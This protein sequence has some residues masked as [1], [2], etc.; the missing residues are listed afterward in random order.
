MW[1]QKGDRRKVHWVKWETLC[2]PKLEGGMGFKDLANFNDTLLA[3]QAW[4]LLHQKNSLFYRVFKLRF[5]PNCSILEAS[6]LSSGS[7]AWH[8]I[9][10][11]RDLLLKGAQWRVG[12]GD[13]ISVWN[14]AWLPSKS[15][16]RIESQVVPGF[17]E[18]KV[19]A[20]IGPITKKWDSY[21]LN[22]L[23]TPQEAKLILSIPLCQNVVEDTVV[24]PF[25]P[26]GNYT[27]KLSTRFLTADQTTTQREEPEQASNEVWKSIWILNVQSKVR[28]FL[29][30]TYH[31]ALPVKQ[32]LRQRHI[33]TEDVCELYKNET[34]LVL[35]ALWSCAQLKQV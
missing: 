21:L 17:E 16:P 13:A 10:K 2:K 23:F 22:G 26:S 9:L 19:S 30:R 5:F 27:V 18:M 25:T 24:W 15:H 3:K 31:N 32:N 4:Q 35:H 20:L 1:G 34:E 6:H 29:W 7:Y 14:N 8:S 28:N 11:G 33:L 12:Y